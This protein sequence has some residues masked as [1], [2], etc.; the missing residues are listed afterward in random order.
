MKVSADIRNGTVIGRCHSPTDFGGAAKI[1]VQQWL[2]F[3]CTGIGFPC[4]T[5][6]T[7][8]PLDW[9]MQSL[10]S[11]EVSA[12]IASNF[13]HSIE[14]IDLGGAANIHVQ[15][16]CLKPLVLISTTFEFR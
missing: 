1:H 11:L 15:Q 13:V 16:W 9:T 3:W 8:S 14:P 4:I 5:R 10:T 2:G 6:S 12:G 7:S